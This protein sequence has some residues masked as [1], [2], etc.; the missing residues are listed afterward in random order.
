M[1]FPD[2]TLLKASG[3]EVDMIQGQQ[4]RD[5]PD[6][7][8]FNYMG[9]NWGAVQT[10]SDADWATIPVGPPFP[11]RGDGVLLIGSNLGQLYIMLNGRRHSIPPPPR[12]WDDLCPNFNVSMAQQVDDADLNAIPL[13]SIFSTPLSMFPDGTLLKA[14]GPE[15]DMFQGWVGRRHIPDPQTFNYMG[16]NW[17]AVQTIS[18]AFWA[19]LIP[20]GPPFPSRADGTLLQGS[21]SEVYVMGNGDRHWIPDPA[22]FDALGYKWSNV[23]PV[24][25]ADLNAIPLGAQVP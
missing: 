2:G 8:T 18:D 22:T 19:N 16:L 13:G 25:D 15:V 14:S 10:I 3:P 9:L 20:I 17:G 24:A 1:S 4:R 11:S 12:L 23:Q 6:P 21:G 7:Q 5:I